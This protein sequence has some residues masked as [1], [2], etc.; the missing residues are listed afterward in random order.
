MNTP[1]V[2]P[3]YMKNGKDK[4]SMM[5]KIWTIINILYDFFKNEDKVILWLDTPNGNFGYSKPIDV[6]NAGR[7]DKVLLY[8]LNAKKENEPPT[9]KAH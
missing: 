9:L 1:K 7:V 4:K 8:C 6:I 5:K 2:H 3:D